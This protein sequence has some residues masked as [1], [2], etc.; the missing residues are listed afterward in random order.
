MLRMESKPAT[1]SVLLFLVVLVLGLSSCSSLADRDRI[2][3]F[4]DPATK[5]R[6][7]ALEQKLDSLESTCRGHFE[8]VAALG[9]R[10]KEIVV[11]LERL[12]A[13]Q[14]SAEQR[15]I[16]SEILKHLMPASR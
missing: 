11:R 2:E 6:L 5:T 12:E 8:A 10:N 7:E 4:Q 13:W 3:E 15:L 9:I 16:I 14:K 1:R